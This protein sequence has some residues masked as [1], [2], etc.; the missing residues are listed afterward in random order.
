MIKTDIFLVLNLLTF[1]KSP[2]DHG[3]L[4]PPFLKPLREEP[5]HPL[6]YDDGRLPH[7]EV[8]LPLPVASPSAL[9]DGRDV[10]LFQ[11]ER[12]FRFEECL[13]EA[14]EDLC[15]GMFELEY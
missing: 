5:P 12:V 4:L 11:L 2:D 6:L 1:N 15:A 7:L 10:V 8:L 13:R 3:G 9:D 14:D